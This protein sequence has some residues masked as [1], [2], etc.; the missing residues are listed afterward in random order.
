MDIVYSYSLQYTEAIHVTVLSSRHTNPGMYICRVLSGS[1]ITHTDVLHQ[2]VAHD[3]YKAF[4]S[5][6]NNSFLTS[7]EDIDKHMVSIL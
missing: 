7:R 2:F 3:L 5:I 4:D 6:N 1:L